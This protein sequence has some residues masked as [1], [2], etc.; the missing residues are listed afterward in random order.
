MRLRLE[1]LPQGAEGSKPRGQT[2]LQ[3]A[4]RRSVLGLNLRGSSRSHGD[5]GGQCLVL[6]QRCLLRLQRCL[7]LG[8][9]ER[10]LLLLLQSANPTESTN[11]CADGL[12]SLLPQASELLG[13]CLLCSQLLHPC[14]SVSAAKGLLSTSNLPCGSKS[15]LACLHLRL[16][17]CL[18]QTKERLPQLRARPKALLR[19]LAKHPAE[20]L[21]STK[22]LL[23]CLPHLLSQLLLRTKLLACRG[24]EELAVALTCG[25]ALLRCRAGHA[26]ELLLSAEALRCGL[27]KLAS[28]R[29]L[30]GK[31]L[32]GFGTKLTSEGLSCA[33]TLGTGL[34]HALRLSGLGCKAL[35]FRLPHGCGKAFASTEFL[36]G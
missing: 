32:L 21:L 13:G 35:R 20:L 3:R 9:E 15:L 34:A 16:L 8:V 4:R 29:L 22:A 6:G 26:C 1:E 33:E 36:P 28:E 31:A 12:L 30:R 24:L 18:P 5:E 17:T 25:K 11:V 19:L 7:T 14:L 10:L 2:S 27:T 23:S